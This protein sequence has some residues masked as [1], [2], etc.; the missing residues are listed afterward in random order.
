MSNIGANDLIYY[1]DNEG[2]IY[3]GGFS[4]NSIM[5]KEGLSPIMT[6]NNVSSTNQHDNISDLFS[7]LVIPSW[8]LHHENIKYNSHYNDISKNNLDYDSDG[9][10]D[11]YISDDLYEKL[12]GLVTVSEKELKGGKNNTRKMKTKIKK[13]RNTR[14]N[15]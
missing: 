7:D 5:I 13:N 9:E 10:S 4:V 2:K 15:K 12:L 6:L 14:R 1:S 8:T 11:G 3:S